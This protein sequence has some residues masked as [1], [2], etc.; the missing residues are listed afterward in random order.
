MKGFV[1]WQLAIIVDNK[2][3]TKIFDKP[4]PVRIDTYFVDDV[5]YEISVLVNPQDETFRVVEQKGSSESSENCKLGEE[6]DKE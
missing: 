3:P 4:I 2:S 6:S 5:R 1:S